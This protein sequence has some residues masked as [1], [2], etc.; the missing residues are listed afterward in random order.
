MNNERKSVKVINLNASR[1]GISNVKKEI[2]SE[3]MKLP[4]FL[5]RLTID[6]CA[7]N[8]EERQRIVDAGGEV[9][10]DEFGSYR[11]NRLVMS[12]KSIVMV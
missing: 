3:I 1:Y 2:E 4:K 11:V 12:Q 6:H 8:P 5:Q 9:T 7:S 10:Q